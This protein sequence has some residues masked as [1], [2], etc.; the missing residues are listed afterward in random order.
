VTLLPNA[1]LVQSGRQAMTD[2]FMH[3]PMMGVVIGVAWA[4]SQWA[5]KQ[6][7]LRRVAAWAAGAV[8]T[9][10]GLLTIRQ[11]GFWHDSETL[12]RH[13]IAVADSGYMRANL[14]TTLMEQS[15]YREAEPQL[16]AAIHL[17]PS[18]PGYHQDL[19]L[20]LFRTGRPDQAAP[21]SQAA[22]ALAP[23][24]PTMREFA[25]LIAL[26]RGKYPEALATMATPSGSV[27]PPI[28]SRGS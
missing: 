23:H 18:E 10:L 27:P 7:A 9:T 22:V 17:E 3:I 24:D 16:A 5:G 25:G 6:R 28:A 2:R 21:E 8:L 20:L 13:S 26:R 4:A 19:A 1:G 12:F 11:I 15:R 14:A